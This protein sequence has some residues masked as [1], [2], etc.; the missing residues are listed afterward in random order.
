MPTF[1][2]INFSLKVTRIN[3]RSFDKLIGFLDLYKNNLYEKPKTEGISFE[4]FNEIY[5]EVPAIEFSLYS[6]VIVNFYTI[7]E[8]NRSLILSKIPNISTID[9]KNIHKIDVVTEVL[10]KNSIVHE[11]IKSYLDMDEFRLVNN[12]IKHDKN[13]SPKL[14]NV[15]NKVYETKD[16][17]QLYINKIDNLDEYLFDLY[18]QLKPLW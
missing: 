7:L 4:D 12:S 17:K 10:E 14:I 16:L 5:F 1:E 13:N 6:L 11:D 3:R 8:K 18:S 9:K 2:E 15:K